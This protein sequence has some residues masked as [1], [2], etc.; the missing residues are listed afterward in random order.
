MFKH[1]K[2]ILIFPIFIIALI[3]SFS[4]VSPVFAD[5]GQP[6]DPPQTEVTLPPQDGAGQMEPVD[7]VDQPETPAD[8]AIT[9]ELPTDPEI[10][11]AA[12]E[13]PFIDN[14]VPE[15]LIQDSVTALSENEIILVEPSG[16]P[17]AMASRSSS[18]LVVA[19]DPYFTVGSVKY[20]FMKLGGCGTL[21][22]C[23]ES[24]TPIQAAL[25]FMAANNLTPT[26]RKL[27]I[28]ADTYNEEVWVNGSLNGVKGLTGLVGKGLTPEDVQINGFLYISNMLSGFSVSNLSVTNTVYEDDAAIWAWNNKGTIQLVDVNATA[29]GTDSSGIIIDHS[30]TVDLNRVNASGNAYMG[31]RIYNAG[32]V[33]ITNSAFD[34]NLNDVDDGI[35][36]DEY[37][38]EYGNY[39]Y[40]SPS[41]AGLEINNGTTS[42]VTLYGV[43]A[44]ENAGD[45]A[46]INAW[47]STISIKNSVFDNNDEFAAVDG[48]GDGLWING[49]IV[50]L[51]NIQASGND[52]RG[53]VS[54]INTSF[55]GLHLH[56]ESNGGTGIDIQGCEDWGDSDPW[57]DNTGT[58]TVTIKI[59]SSSGNGGD[60]FNVETKGAVT[61]S[62]VYSGGNS[63]D[64]VYVDNSFAPTPASITLTNLD[65]NG[66][67]TGIDL[68]TRGAVSIKNFK[69]NGNS[70]DGVY[71][72]SSGTGAI[73]LTNATAVFNE[74]GYNG[75][76]GYYILSNGAITIT[77]LDSWDNGL[78]GGY[79][80]NSTASAAAAVTI[81]TLA[82]VNYYNGY[83]GNGLGG[84]FINSRGAVTISR[85]GANN[86]YRFGAE[87][88]NIP[89][90]IVA[91]VPVT[92]S[93][94]TFYE[95]Y[96]NGLVVNSKGLITLTNV[97]AQYNDGIGVELNNQ[98]PGATGGVTINATANNGNAFIGNTLEG[99]AIYTNG[100]VTITNIYANDNG[101][102]GGNGALILNCHWHSRCDHQTAWNLERQGLLD[103]RQ[104]LLQQQLWRF[105]HRHKWP[106]HC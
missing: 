95:N 18:D 33:K 6:V 90:G 22:N 79:I 73:T 96:E 91:G 92:I 32:A 10:V 11:D 34:N 56:A 59:S 39:L 88:H 5:D 68:F 83:W 66:N 12:L 17:V 41:Y 37:Y 8:P 100:A 42:P 87:I 44:Q 78:M 58:G 31:A 89:P 85:I 55:N 9:T 54:H 45:G 48:W 49:S 25:D 19:G 26:D 94:S 3:L 98:V 71:I 14:T 21:T 38:D 103:R 61:I 84:L 23:V 36:Y 80:D 86:N 24:P 81:N 97:A 40:N 43:S 102:S 29:T 2:M 1:N 27:Y 28:E 13:E 53:I 106:S 62:D 82:P 51:E 50:T 46:N 30:G 65:I 69:S 64:G 77:N 93:N 20:S 104:F 74:T 60:G 72:E 101:Y 75:G 70:V 99:L 76:Y 4:S 67:A 63:G 57:C 7:V 35:F 47:K 15:S 16:E 52:M 105:V